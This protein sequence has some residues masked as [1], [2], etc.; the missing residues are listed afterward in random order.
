M[1]VLFPRNETIG[2][3]VS[4][5]RSDSAGWTGRLVAALGQ[6][7]TRAKIFMDIDA[8]SAGQD[9]HAAIESAS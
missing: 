6:R 8:V 7:F 5:R 1:G 2:V 9:F 3:F 4:Y